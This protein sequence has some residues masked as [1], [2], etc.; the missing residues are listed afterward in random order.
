MVGG[1]TLVGGN[2]SELTRLPGGAELNILPANG[3]YDNATC[4]LIPVFGMLL[5]VLSY[6]VIL[7]SKGSLICFLVM[8]KYF[9]SKFESRV[10]LNFLFDM[11]AK[12]I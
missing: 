10:V 1:V 9:T 11:G 5:R 2:G 4:I 12:L 6:A 7:H 3:A 8:V